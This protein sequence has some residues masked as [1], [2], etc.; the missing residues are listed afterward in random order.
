MTKSVLF[1]FLTVV[2]TLTFV[3]GRVVEITKDNFN[4]LSKGKNAFV[5]FFAPWCGHCKAM[6]PAWDQLG[7][8][9]AGSSSVLIGDADCTGSG[10]SLCSEFGVQGYPTVKYFVDGNTQGEKY[11]G[12]RDYDS[13]LAF[14]KE[15][16][17]VKCDTKT[18]EGCTDKEKE[19]IEKMK[20]KSSEERVKQIKRLE[21]MA[22]DPMK[23]EL[24]AWL[25]QRLHI[26][27]KL[28]A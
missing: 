12:A 20:A 9:Y 17:E 7:E 14:T 16:L 24:K 21:G 25:R 10:E 26:L 8:T 5:K 22:S 23:A 11:N 6:K 27:N 2:S 18:G 4:E 1:T 15:N 13:L 19:Y 28:E 3:N